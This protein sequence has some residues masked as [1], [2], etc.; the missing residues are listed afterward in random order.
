[1]RFFIEETSVRIKKMR[2][3]LGQTSNYS[4]KSGARP[5]RF[6]TDTKDDPMTKKKKRA[7]NVLETGN[8]SLLSSA[9]PRGTLPRLVTLLSNLV[10]RLLMLRGRA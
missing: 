5:K 2:Y 1:V 3:T 4:L 7:I 8:S 10:L 6:K 9:F